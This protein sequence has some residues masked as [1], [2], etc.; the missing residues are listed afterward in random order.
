MAPVRRPFFYSVFVTVTSDDCYVVAAM[1]PAPMPAVVMNTILRASVLAIVFTIV[2]PM[3]IS[4]IADVNANSLGAHDA[5]GGYSENRRTNK[6]NFL[7]S[8]LRL[9]A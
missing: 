8:F 6:S 5:R 3:A 7:H 4:I 2:I 9:K 1:F